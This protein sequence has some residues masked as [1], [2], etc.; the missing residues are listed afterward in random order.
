MTNAKA[1]PWQLITLCNDGAA[2][3]FPGY[4]AV[5]MAT[6]ATSIASHLLHHEVIALALLVANCLAYAM[7]SALTIVR[8]AC[9]PRS[10][11]ND[12]VDHARGPGFFTLIAG[13]SILG[14]QFQ[15]LLGWAD[16]A[17]V[18]WWLGV[19]L[20]GCIM[21][22]FFISVTIRTDK[23]TL[24]EGINGAW[25]L[26]AV[27]T[28][29]VAILTALVPWSGPEDLRLFFALCMFMIGCMLYLA[30]ITLIFYR[31]TFLKLSAENL[32]PPYW[33]NMGAVAITTLAGSTLIVRAH[34]G[35]VLMDFL[36]FLRGFTLFFWAVA[37]WWIPLLLGLTFWRHVLK[38]HQLR[39]EPQLWSLVFPLAMY[40]TGTI[41]LADALNT[42]FLLIIPGVTMWL[43]WGA[44]LFTSMGMWRHF[45]HLI[46]NRIGRVGC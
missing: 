19:S 39:Y 41:R 5:V 28:Q 4:F 45:A 2:G 11:V 15:I 44:W 27:S 8:A 30:I 40:T 24:E 16:V 36:P 17:T 7:L 42:D 33:I 6:G 37:T 21:Y 31:L 18:F 35:G 38:H 29:S 22:L 9:Y 25:L 32:S 14:A 3:L 26:A 10:L 13:T 1:L 23:P 12:M 20:W 46:Q 34:E 43:A